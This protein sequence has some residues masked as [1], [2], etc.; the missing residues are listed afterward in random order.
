MSNT[1][2]SSRYLKIVQILY[3][4]NLFAIGRNPK[5]KI[6]RNFVRIAIGV[7]FAYTGISKRKDLFKK[8]S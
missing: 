3:L 2:I 7:G 5:H 8:R 4:E 1:N 6:G